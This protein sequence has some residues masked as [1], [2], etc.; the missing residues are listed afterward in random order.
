MSATS[1]INQVGK[2]ED[3]ADIIAVVDARE[4]VLTSTLKKGKK[5][6]NALVEFQ[7]DSY[8]TVSTAGVVDGTDVSFSGSEDFAA[9]RARLGNYIQ[10]FRRTPG[11]T[12][13]A[14]TVAVVAGV[15]NADPNGTAGSTEFNR[16]KAKAVVQI[17]RDVEAT[18][19]SANGAQADNG[20]V[21]FKTRG[22]GKWLS[23]TAD[24]VQ[25]QPSSA[26]LPSGQVYD[27]AINS[28]QTLANFNEESLRTLLQ[29]R[30]SNT[31]RAANLIMVT[32]SD[33]KN[34]VTDFS[35]FLPSRSANTS[36][37]FYNTDA[38][39][40]KVTSTVDFY[41]GD[42]GSLEL[43]LSAFVP[44][45]ST[46]YILDPDYAEIRTH[47]APYFQQLPDLGGGPRGIVETILALCVTGPKA[48]AKIVC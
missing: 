40:K 36:V 6:A 41:D 47:T 27:S 2:R 18:L 15:N 10:T 29:T 21:P 33:I 19:L 42:F 34:S 30:W 32:G 16:A 43:H 3:L 35:R 39:D 28:A 13:L 45:T 8:P 4:T 17:K 22:L 38:T 7:V 1:Y 37:R 12:R 9:N 11:V 24:S 44:T 46:A 48:H 23:T 5:P 25:P 20:T 31:G 14:E 26:L